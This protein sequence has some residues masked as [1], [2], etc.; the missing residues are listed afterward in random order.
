MRLQAPLL[1]QCMQAF[2]AAAPGAQ[3]GAFSAFLMQHQ[4]AL[5]LNT[6]ALESSQVQTSPLSH[7]FKTV[8]CSSPVTSVRGRRLAIPECGR[9][10][11]CR[12]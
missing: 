12:I 11:E 5:G 7:T 2:K 10:G 9:T 3:F 4:G 1:R 6:Q 8:Y